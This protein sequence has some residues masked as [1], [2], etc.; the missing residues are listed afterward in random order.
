MI[1]RRSF[2]KASSCGVTAAIAMSRYATNAFADPDTLPTQASADTPLKKEIEIF[3]FALGDSN[4]YVIHDGVIVATDFHPFFAPE[5][6]KADVQKL[7]AQ[8]FLPTDHMSLSINTLVLQDKNGEVSLFDSGAG[9]AFGDAAGKTPAGLAK[10]GISTEQVKNVFITHAHPDHIAGLFDAENQIRYKNAKIIIS[11]DE[12]NFWSAASPDLSKMKVPPKDFQ[13]NL[14]S[15]HTFLKIMEPQLEK[16]QASQV[17]PGI[18]AIS[19]AG[20]TPGHFVY[21]ITRARDSILHLGDSVH[22]F[23]LQFAHPEWTMIFDCDPAMAIK[24]RRKLFEE[25][26]KDKMLLCGYHLPFPG[27]GHIKSVAKAYQWVPRP[28]VA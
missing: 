18:E 19:T 22:A 14:E 5:A 6:S 8:N 4:A 27:I 25:H 28:W 7:L 1:S 21:K 2:I 24:T 23:A 13:K 17:R 20:H 10:I 3:S 12:F 9:L 16:V 15:I 26:A 11:N